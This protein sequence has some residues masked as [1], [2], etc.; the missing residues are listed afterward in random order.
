MRPLLLSMSTHYSTI[1]A[2]Y[3]EVSAFSDTVTSLESTRFNGRSHAHVD[4]QCYT[5]T[6]LAPYR[7]TTS[8]RATSNERLDEQNGRITK[9]HTTI[10][11]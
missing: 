6:A 5:R 7:F 1:V 9:Q 2:T 3:C 8:E 4:V 10:R 11:Q